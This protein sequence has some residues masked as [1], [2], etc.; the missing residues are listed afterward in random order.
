MPGLLVITEA[1]S[2]SA[3]AV[4]SVEETAPANKKSAEASEKQ[5]ESPATPASNPTPT[6]EVTSFQDDFSNTDSGWFT[7]EQTGSRLYYDQAGYRILVDQ[8]NIIAWATPALY[9]KDVSIEVDATKVA[10]PDDNLF[11]ILC[12][13]QD[14]NN[15]YLFVIGSNAYYEV[16]KYKHGEYSVI[17]DTWGFSDAIHKGR[18][19]NRIRADCIGSTLTLY[20]NDLKLVEV[21]D[22]EFAGGDVG[23]TAA[24]FKLGNTNIWFDNFV[25]RKP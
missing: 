6:V 18:T 1:P 5:A 3:L 9:F 19:T 24:A 2:T 23:L 7:G 14:E 22:S 25:A 11:G 4:S 10:G 12:R 20:V 21:S 17:E 13:Y 16:G 15:F 8:P